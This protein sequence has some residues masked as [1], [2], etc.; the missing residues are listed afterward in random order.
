[1]HKHRQGAAV[2]VATALLFGS[3]VTTAEAIAP[4]TR[5]NTIQVAIGVPELTSG[6]WDYVGTSEFHRN[7]Y[8]YQQ[9][10]S[11]PKKSTGGNFLTCITTANT[12]SA[13]YQLW[14]AD[15]GRNDNVATYVGGAGCLAWKNIGKYVDGSN[16][17]AEFYIRTD[18]YAAMRVKSYD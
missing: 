17:R 4:P 9:Y 8:P 12:K 16:N 11:K 13:M 14:E 18:D 1:M 2:A 6:G 5:N 15:P 7:P 10:S 3:T